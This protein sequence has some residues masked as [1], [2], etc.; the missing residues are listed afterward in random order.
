M[1]YSFINLWKIL[2]SLSCCARSKNLEIW[3]PYEN[4]IIVLVPLTPKVFAISQ[5]KLTESTDYWPCTDLE[6]GYI[7]RFGKEITFFNII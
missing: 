1:K 6:V 7:I 2:S 5:I 4:L 3:E